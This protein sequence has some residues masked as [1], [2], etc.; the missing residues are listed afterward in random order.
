MRCFF[1][2]MSIIVILFL[3]FVSGSKQSDARIIK[4]HVEDSEKYGS[5]VF[6]DTK[7]GVTYTDIGDY[8]YAV[9]INE[10]Y[11]KKN[12]GRIAIVNDIDIGDEGG[13]VDGVIFK[14]K[15]YKQI[16]SIKINGDMPEVFYIYNFPDLEKIIFDKKMGRDL[17]IYTTVAV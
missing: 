17:Y 1:R 15:C 13:H 16:K 3:A 5:D 4:K 6:F 14:E 7:Y 10:K 12:K 2:A 11:V 8:I 9:D